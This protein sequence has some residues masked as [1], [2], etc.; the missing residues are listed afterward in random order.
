MKSKYKNKPIDN[1]ENL[2]NIK[3]IYE[4]H[5]INN[6]NNAVV[7]YEITPIVITDNIN[8]TQDKI[9][10]FYLEFLKTIDF[11]FKIYIE[12]DYYE[13]KNQNI[14]TNEYKESLREEYFNNLKELVNKNQVFIKTFYLI[15]TVKNINELKELD[16]HINILKNIGL[17]IKLLDS[18]QKIEYVLYKSINRR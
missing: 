2:Y 11:D 5:Y 9:Y 17:E 3:D 6:E 8:E 1:I 7:I 18:K 15:V 4:N 14:T 10:E 16:R 12:N 13:V